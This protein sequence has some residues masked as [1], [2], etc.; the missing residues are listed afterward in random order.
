LARKAAFPNGVE[1]LAANTEIPFNVS[2]VALLLEGEPKKALEIYEKISKSEPASWTA[3]QAATVADRIGDT[4]K[5]DALLKQV[6]E[7]PRPPQNKHDARPHRDELVYLAR[8]L[9]KDLAAGGKCAFNF[10]ELH[11]QRDRAPVRDRSSFN[12]FLGS[13]LDRRGKSNLALEYW[14]QCMGAPDLMMPTRT[15]AGFELHKRGVKPGE[16]K[17]FLFAD[18]KA[19][20]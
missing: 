18:Q 8:Q 15:L 16:W 7:Q 2:A 12:F 17:Q 1:E 6:I 13:Y 14:K 11:A 5:R 3:M 4:T 19:T 10:D 20:K 9:V